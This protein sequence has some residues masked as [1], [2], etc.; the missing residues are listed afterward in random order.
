M[1]QGKGS[2]LW[3]FEVDSYPNNQTTDLS[4]LLVTNKNK[5]MTKLHKLVISNLKSLIT[6]TGNE[7]INQVQLLL[8]L[9]ST[10][11]QIK[12]VK[13]LNFSHFTPFIV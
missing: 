4:K 10:Q 3:K 8:Y 7:A 13:V 12:M 5:K 11:I 6:N 9:V 2:P 1:T